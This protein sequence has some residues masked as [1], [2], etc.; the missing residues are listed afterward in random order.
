[1]RRQPPS[2]WKVGCFEKQRGGN[3][4]FRLSF[5]SLPN[6]ALTHVIS[7]LSSTSLDSQQPSHDSLRRSILEPGTAQEQDV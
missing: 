4:G 5:D 6:L 2:M 1:M 7:N 3:F